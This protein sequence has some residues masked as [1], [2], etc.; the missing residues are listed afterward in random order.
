MV[1][2]P[3]TGY[4][5]STAVGR[6]GVRGM[7]AQARAMIRRFAAAL[8]AV[9]ALSPAACSSW[10]ASTGTAEDRITATAHTQVQTALLVAEAGLE[11]PPAPAVTLTVVLD[12]ARSE[13]V[14]A[15]EDLARLPGDHG[16]LMTLLVE[17]TTLI[18]LTQSAVEDGD[19]FALRSAK[20]S[21][22]E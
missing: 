10:A 12:E 6:T 20:R 19:R 7:G 4:A 9:L 16:G 1:E 14:T 21:A 2:F 15:R 18:G 17:A 11:D 22:E 8:A 13:L 3:S 5:A